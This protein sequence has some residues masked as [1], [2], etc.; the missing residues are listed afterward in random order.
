MKLAPRTPS[1]EISRPLKTFLPYVPLM[2]LI[3]I[4]IQYVCLGYILNV[5]DG[6]ITNPVMW[7]QMKVAGGQLS[8][9][10]R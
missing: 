7:G 2:Y 9:V 8:R 3:H 10:P 1:L 5:C 4:N 6:K